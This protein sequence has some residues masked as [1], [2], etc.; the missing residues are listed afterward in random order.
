MLLFQDGFDNSYHKWTSNTGVVNFYTTTGVWSN[1]SIAINVASAT[2]FSNTIK[3]VF[4]TSS[5]TDVT[6]PFTR[7]SFWMRTQSTV[8]TNSPFL[9]IG[10][11]SRFANSNGRY[12]INTAGKL[13]IHNATTASATTLTPASLAEYGR[14]DDQNWHHIEIGVKYNNSNGNLTLSIDGTQIYN[15]T[16]NN[17][18]GGQ[19]YRLDYVTFGNLQGTAGQ[20]LYLDDVMIWDDYGA[21]ETLTGP[22]GPMRI[23]TLRPAAD[24]YI[25]STAS[26]GNDRYLLLDDTSGPNGDSDYVTLSPYQKDVYELEDLYG[27]VG[28]IKTATATL[29][30]N[31]SN[32][33]RANVR[34]F[35][36]ANGYF[37]NG[38][39]TTALTRTYITPSVQHIFNVDFGNSNVAWT[40]TSIS[41]L[42]IGVE[43]VG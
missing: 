11:G 31:S 9:E 14:L 18:T 15:Y 3:K 35:V 17:A 4:K 26:T 6:N 24:I 25:E 2:A 21:S 34:P 27:P 42:Q 37:A 32:Y 12:S 36:T 13:V 19:Y 33:G 29:V 7:L 22:Q 38:N 23:Y 28:A 5:D 8:T 20:I 43:N 1:G 30:Y 40:N 16:G 10:D 41:G 39:V